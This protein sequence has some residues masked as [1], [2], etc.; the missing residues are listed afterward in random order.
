MEGKDFGRRN[1]LL[2]QP[3]EWKGVDS[4]SVPSFIFFTSFSEFIFG[5]YNLFVDFSKFLFMPDLLPS[6]FQFLVESTFFHSI[7]V[8]FL[9]NICNI[10][11]CWIFLRLVLFLFVSFLFGSIDIE[12]IVLHFNI[13]LSP[14]LCVLFSALSNLLQ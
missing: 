6:S 4:N 10:T 11:I 3:T 1:G 13:I 12:A 7:L 2:Y 9:L 5:A 14:V 8:L